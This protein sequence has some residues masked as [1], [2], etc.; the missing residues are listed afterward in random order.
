MPPEALPPRGDHL[1][2]GRSVRYEA[3][4]CARLGEAGRVLALPPGCDRC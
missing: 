4:H 1:S 2:E 3:S